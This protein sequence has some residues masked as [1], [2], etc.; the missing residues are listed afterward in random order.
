MTADPVSLLS[1]ATDQAAA[2]ISNVSHEQAGRPTPCPGWTVGRLI[3]HIIDDL[4][5]FTVSAR[6]GK[7][8]FSSPP[9]IDDWDDAFERDQA[10]LLDAWRSAG[11]LT[12]TMDLP[13]IGTVPK[14]FPVDQATAEFATHTWDLA[15]ATNQAPTLDPEIALASL[16]WARGALRDEYRS[17]E[18]GATFGRAINVADDAPPYDRL[19]GFFGRNPADWP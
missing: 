17:D 14:R 11:D 1:R 19:A 4:R 5:Q 10:E 3:D 2:I 16:E 8:N 15:K 13:H 18:P 6:G 7:A 12:G 9:K